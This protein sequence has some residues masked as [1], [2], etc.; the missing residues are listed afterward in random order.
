MV[1]ARDDAAT[2]NS[3]ADVDM[4]KLE[5]SFTARA[6]ADEKETKKQLASLKQELKDDEDRL[7]HQMRVAVREGKSKV[8]KLLKKEVSAE[9][10]LM[11]EKKADG[12]EHELEQVKT[13]EAAKEKEI[14]AQLKGIKSEETAAIQEA[15]PKILAKASVTASSAPT[16]AAA[17][18]AAPS[19]GAGEERRQAAIAAKRSAFLR[20]DM[21][22]ADKS[23]KAAYDRERARASSTQHVAEHAR[24]THASQAQEEKKAK[25][26]AAAAAAAAKAAKKKKSAEEQKRKEIEAAAE[27]LADARE[28]AFEGATPLPLPMCDALS[29]GREGEER[30]N[31]CA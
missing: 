25:A 21:K 5:A 13:S 9:T 3:A 29:L 19:A 28:K 20:D 2:G 12:L 30:E 22:S 23:E 26:A 10:A 7:Y 16:S 18:Q 11:A 27:K 4:R 8:K 31:V 6:V 1:D 15:D 24:A 17:P 14:K